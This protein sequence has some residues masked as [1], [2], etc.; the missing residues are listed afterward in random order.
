MDVKRRAPFAALLGAAAF[1]LLVRRPAMATETPAYAIVR[2]WEDAEFRQCGPTIVAQTRV[3]G[4]R[5]FAGTEGFRRL[6][7]YIFGGNRSRAFIAMTAPVGQAP[8][9]GAWGVRFT[10]PARWT[11]DTLLAGRRLRAG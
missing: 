3:E 1:A 8:A 4:P 6:S 9:D 7:G 10:M 5:E 11:L 2:A